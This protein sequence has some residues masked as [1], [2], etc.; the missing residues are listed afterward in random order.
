MLSA[1]KAHR[2]FVH[3]AAKIK[4]VARLQKP[5]ILFSSR[6]RGWK[7][8]D[9]DLVRIP[10]GLASARGAAQH[11]L[12]MHLGPPVNADCAVDGVRM[13]GLQKP[14]DIG[15][16][17]AGVEGSWEDDAD[18]HLL[19]LSLQPSLLDEVAEQLGK[20]AVKVSLIPLFQLR[21]PRIEAIGWAV[22][23][24]LEAETPSDPLYIDLLTNALAVRLVELVTD[25]RMRSESPRQSGMSTRQMRVLV[26]FIESNLDQK[27]HLVDLASVAGI[28]ATRLK[29]L[30]RNSTGIPVH[31][32]VIR[33]R[34]E[35]ARALMS[36][37]RMPASEIAAAAGF[38]HQS[39]M[40][41]TMRRILGQTPRE[42]A[43]P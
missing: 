14:G 20:A 32:Y 40:A 19:R 16:V 39:H 33:R 29:T 21:D 34:V 8:L 25:R 22:K 41:T 9:A 36:T 43:R 11:L 18:C 27:L 42:I 13:R 17:P 3:W 38:A 30:F 28:S 23:A 15:V 4:L 1:H 12:G 6:Y 10:A 2:L 35:Y 5:E 31:Q 37:T 7:A 26:D 24:D